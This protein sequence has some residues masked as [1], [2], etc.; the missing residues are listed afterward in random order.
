[1]SER[2]RSEAELIE[3]YLAPLTRGAAG[4]FGLKDD[5]A[6]IELETG[7]DL[8]VSTD[9][10]VSGVHFFANDDAAD[11]AWKALA[12]NVSD[13]VAK[14]A[15]PIGYTMALAFPDAPSVS[16]MTAFASGLRQAQDAFGMTLVG[17]DTD[18][19]SGPLSISV[20]AFGAVPREAFVPRGGARV[21]DHVFVSGTLGDAALGLKLHWD[22]SAVEGL[23]AAHK[24]DLVGRYLRPQPRFELVPVLRTYA[25]AA[26]DISDGLVKDLKRLAA[27]AGSAIDVRFSAL[28]LSAALQSALAASADTVRT[29]VLSGGDDYEVLF[30]VTE[31]DIPALK[32]AAREAGVV[33][34][35]VGR[36]VAGNGVR[37]LDD[38]GLEIA[39]SSSG[40]DHFA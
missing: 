20:T 6:L 35:E 38:I 2:I 1:M 19:T 23:D 12:V 3:T 11:I 28:P 37:V 13:L 36:L 9:P 30:A 31:G 15:E 5:A 39:I 14:G 32:R 24:A 10:I 27:G 4:A 7:M 34:T 22:P 16:W 17:G 29:A 25:T 18:R 33:I 8:V 40:F 21:G 26:L